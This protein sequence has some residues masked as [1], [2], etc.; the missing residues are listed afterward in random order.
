MDKYGIYK[1]LDS[2]ETMEKGEIKD[3]GIGEGWIE[4][5]SASLYLGNHKVY[6]FKDFSFL[7]YDTVQRKPKGEVI[8]ITR[9]D[10]WAGLVTE[11]F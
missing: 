6:F 7:K 5:L 4:D 8:R 9:D 2:L 11:S 1:D 10:E 3:L